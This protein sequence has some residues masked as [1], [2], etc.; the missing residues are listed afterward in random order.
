MKNLSVSDLRLAK[1]FF[2]P[3]KKPPVHCICRGFFD[4]RV[5]L[6]LTVFPFICPFNLCFAALQETE[7]QDRQK[8]RR[9]SVDD[10]WRVVLSLFDPVDRGVRTFAQA[11]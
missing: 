8:M 7:I 9:V 5:L 11:S 6:T 3:Q 10:E 1:D 4:S 2:P